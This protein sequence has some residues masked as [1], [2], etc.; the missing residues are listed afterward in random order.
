MTMRLGF[1]KFICK[2]EGLPFEVPSK[3]RYKVK[4]R[5]LM[6]HHFDLPG[7]YDFHRLWDLCGQIVSEGVG[8]ELSDP[9]DV[10][11]AFTWETHVMEHEWG[12]LCDTGVITER[13]YLV[14]AVWETYLSDMEDDYI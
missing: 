11:L 14:A 4:D 3:A 7:H 2:V 9:L 6:D 13:V 8:G 10:D 12:D 1:K 5:G